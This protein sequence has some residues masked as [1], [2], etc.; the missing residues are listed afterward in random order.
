MVGVSS[1][2]EG[3]ARKLGEGRA[4]ALDAPV[5]CRNAPHHLEDGSLSDA[6]EPREPHRDA[7]GL[8]ALLTEGV[9]GPEAEVEREEALRRDVEEAQLEG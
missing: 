1:G 6:S 9:R 4:D 8:E 3:P 7:R 2:L 5:A